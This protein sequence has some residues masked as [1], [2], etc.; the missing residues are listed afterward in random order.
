MAP[1]KIMNS[2]CQFGKEFICT[3]ASAGLTPEAIC[4]MNRLC[5]A[6]A[7]R[8]LHS[9]ST[10]LSLPLRLCF[11]Q[12]FYYFI[13]GTSF[14]AAKIQVDFSEESYFTV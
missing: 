5:T 1:L 4:V 2:S 10:E 13:L 11:Y 12:L 3:L 8:L 7:S 9:I 14:S 6:S